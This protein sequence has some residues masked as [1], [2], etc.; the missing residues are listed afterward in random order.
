MNSTFVADVLANWEFER[1]VETS[2]LQIRTRNE[3]KTLIIVFVVI[4]NLI[5][6][7]SDVL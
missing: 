2:S 4:H 7:A 3:H 5:S 6:I 1:G